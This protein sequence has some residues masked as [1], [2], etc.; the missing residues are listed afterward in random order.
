MESLLGLAGEVGALLKAKKQTVGVAESSGGGLIS[1][2]LLS[3]AGA[4]A[5]FVAGG[6]VYTPIARDKIAGIADAEMR[7]V[8]SS[9]EPYAVLL[10]SRMRERTGATWGVAETGAAGPT[11]N[12][13][14]DPA[15]HT[16]IAISGPVDYVM[17]YQ[18]GEA[19]RID[20]MRAFARRAL[21]EFKAAIERSQ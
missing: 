4:S 3:V 12:R 13:Y 5:Y 21:E 1:A 7:G 15:G 19:G 8:R 11:G 6:V 10:A 17:T 16:C 18:T 9:S 20:N 14:G 2:S